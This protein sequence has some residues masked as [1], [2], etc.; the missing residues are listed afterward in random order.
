[1]NHVFASIIFKKSE[2]FKDA[3]PIKPPSTSALE[4]ISDMN[5]EVSVINILGAEMVKLF[6]GKVASKYYEIPFDLTAF[7]KGIYFVKVRSDGKV[8]M[9]D[10][11]LVD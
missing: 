8:I 1:M 9:T 3:P 2:E 6:D 5:V 11:I 10:K 4:N 7:D